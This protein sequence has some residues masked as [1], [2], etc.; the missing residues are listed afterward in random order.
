[1]LPFPTTYRILAGSLAKNGSSWPC[2]AA[3]RSAASQSETGDRQG[4]G[5]DLMLQPPDALGLPLHTAWRASLISS[6]YLSGAPYSLA[7][8]ACDPH[9]QH[10]LGE[11]AT[12]NAKP[13]TLTKR[14]NTSFFSFRDCSRCTLISSVYLSSLYLLC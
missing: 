3:S 7:R 4:L 2:S 12:N 13:Q 14:N 1:V 8:L 10:K 9:E 11:A 5:P 6:V